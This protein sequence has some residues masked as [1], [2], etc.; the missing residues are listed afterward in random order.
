MSDV[1][2]PSALPALTLSLDGLKR[3]GLTT[4]DLPGVGGLLS[5]DAAELLARAAAPIRRLVDM[6]A[7]AYRYVM[8][9][10]DER[11][12]R[13]HLDGL[14]PDLLAV[15][16]P[17]ARQLSALA[18]RAPKGRYVQPVLLGKVFGAADYVSDRRDAL[19]ALPDLP[20]K[21]R[22]EIVAGQAFL[23][24]HP[25]M[26]D[27]ALSAVPTRD[28]LEALGKLDFYRSMAEAEWKATSARVDAHYRGAV[29]NEARFARDLPVFRA[30]YAFTYY[31]LLKLDPV[32]G[33]LAKVTPGAIAAYQRFAT[34]R[35]RVERLVEYVR[36]AGIDPATPDGLGEDPEASRPMR[37]AASA[38]RLPS[39]DR[40]APRFD[41][42]GPTAPQAP[43]TPGPQE[44]AS[45]AL[46]LAGRRS[47][48][49]AQGSLPATSAALDLTERRSLAPAA[50]APLETEAAAPLA[51]RLD[52]SASRGLP[53]PPKVDL[54][55]EPLA[56]VEVPA[57]MRAHASLPVGALPSGGAL[58]AVEDEGLPTQ[59]NAPAADTPLPDLAPPA[60][61]SFDFARTAPTPTK[62]F[63]EG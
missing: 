51:A 58:P 21:L 49:P 35:A 5:V 1:D 29:E 22:D 40:L 34:H 56:A 2:G 30:V 14:G 59:P 9:V 62:L 11:T 60:T 23:R 26:M 38:S 20:A 46:D 16:V 41:D 53:P 55:T 50:A 61:R 39:T 54:P 44:P 37:A 52:I 27:A 12:V 13:A 4:A 8:Q 18:A 57:S 7:D 15:V 3:P 28:Q 6:P 31:G 33:Y 24:R 17:A 45:S 10:P 43:A 36:E 32:T 48:T 25:R 42:A 63:D 19:A 47:L